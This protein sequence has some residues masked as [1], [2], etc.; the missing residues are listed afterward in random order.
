MLL[1]QQVSSLNSLV[2]ENLARAY[3]VPD[4]GSTYYEPKL[5]CY[6]LI[7]DSYFGEKAIE[8]ELTASG[9]LMCRTEDDRFLMLD[10]TDLEKSPELLGIKYRGLPIKNT[11]LTI[12]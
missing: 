6:F 10:E 3:T 1:N 5:G 4:T 11:T 12:I 7:G 2:S 9:T 8:I